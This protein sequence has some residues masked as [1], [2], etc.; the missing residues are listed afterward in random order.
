MHRHGSNTA[1][2]K[3]SGKPCSIQLLTH[4]ARFFVLISHFP[5]QKQ[6]LIS[7]HI[8]KRQIYDAGHESDDDT[9]L[10]GE[11]MKEGDGTRSKPV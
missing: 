8:L 6:V 5:Y 1:D 9:P 11:P 10:P 3:H 4:A 7:K 2:A